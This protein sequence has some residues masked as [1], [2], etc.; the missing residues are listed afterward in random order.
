MLDV[1]N[2]YRQIIFKLKSTPLLIFGLVN[3]LLCFALPSSSL[4]A[5]PIPFV[6]VLRTVEAEVA[7]INESLN[8]GESSE[9]LNTR[10]DQLNHQLD[11][12]FTQFWDQLPSDRKR[13]HLYSAAL[14]EIMSDSGSALLA[15]GVIAAPILSVVE[16]AGFY[17]FQHPVGWLDGLKT[18]AES[19]GIGIVGL[20]AN[21]IMGAFLMNS[22]RI[23]IHNIKEAV[24]DMES[25]LSQK[26]RGDR[27]SYYWTLKED[28]PGLP[29]REYQV[30]A[31]RPQIAILNRTNGRTLLIFEPTVYNTRTLSCSELLNRQK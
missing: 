27:R 10:V 14:S 25:V 21:W 20:G 29:T 5:E 23:L 31:S 2:H 3:T 9:N 24:L 19:L 28:A 6:E 7:S 4:C 12:A 13:A 1:F 8:S 30:R 11:A 15:D 17:Y 18:A 26:K 22:L 16:A